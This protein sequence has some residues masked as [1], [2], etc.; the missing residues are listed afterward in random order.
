MAKSRSRTTTVPPKI[1]MTAFFFIF[2]CVTHRDLHSFPTR[3]SSDLDLANGFIVLGLAGL[4]TFKLLG[5][6]AP[7]TSDSERDRKSTR[8]NSSHSQISYAVFCLKKKG[9]VK[10]L[11][12][13]AP[14]RRPPARASVRNDPQH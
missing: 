1:V 10:R 12:H 13:D 14:V 5:R 4:A 11:E 8:L 9:R 2:C 7:S 3:R 6:G